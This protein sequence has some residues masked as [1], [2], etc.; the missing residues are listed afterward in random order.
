[1]VRGYARRRDRPRHL[2]HGREHDPGRDA[3]LNALAIAGVVFASTFLGALLGMRIS[4]A[5]PEQ[6]LD[7]G[8]KDLVR[9]CMGLIATM[10]ALILGL[11]TASAKEAFDSQGAAVRN[12]A[13][14]LITL[15]RTLAAFGPEANPIRANLHELVRTRLTLM[16]EGAPPVE[17]QAGAGRT[18]AEG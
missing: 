5:L 14:E 8:S 11:V 18:P 10:T 3:A 15:D 17:A 6:H 16:E 4:V 12:A 2:L 1:A 13:T 9:L 7:A